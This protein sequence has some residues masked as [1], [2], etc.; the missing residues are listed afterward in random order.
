MTLVHRAILVVYIPDSCP[1]NII[2]AHYDIISFHPPLSSTI[3]LPTKINDYNSITYLLI[4]HTQLG[5]GLGS[6]F[7]FHYTLSLVGMK[8]TLPAD[9]G[10]LSLSS[11]WYSVAGPQSPHWEVWVL[12]RRWHKLKRMN[13][14]CI[15]CYSS[16]PTC[17]DGF[18]TNYRNLFVKCLR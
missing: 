4:S 8:W 11:L 18:F 16:S 14:W 6:T 17:K 2:R 7:H 10:T 12:H 15:S 5:W 1:W 13:R 3:Q 9:T